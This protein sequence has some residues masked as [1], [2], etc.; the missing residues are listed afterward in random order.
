LELKDYIAEN[1]GF[2]PGDLPQGLQM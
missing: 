2:L 1:P